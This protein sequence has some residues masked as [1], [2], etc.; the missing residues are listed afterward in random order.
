MPDSVSFNIY[1]KSDVHLIMYCR[2]F[3]YFQLE[4]CYLVTSVIKNHIKIFGN[5]REK[6]SILLR[7]GYFYVLFLYCKNN[8]NF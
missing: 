6:Y 4:K 2:I 1:N 5:K 7:A 3:C 8:V